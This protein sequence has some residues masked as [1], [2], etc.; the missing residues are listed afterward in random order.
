MRYSAILGYL[1]TSLNLNPENGLITI[2]TNNHGFDR[3]QMPEYRLY[4]EARDNDGMGNT[5][6]VII[7]FSNKFQINSNIFAYREGSIDFKND[8]C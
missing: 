2:S 1:N 5:A 3:E 6:Q 7:I 8:R 4:V